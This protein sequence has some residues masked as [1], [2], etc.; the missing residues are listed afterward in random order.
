MRRLPPTLIVLAAVVLGVLSP[1]RS[2]G[3]DEEEEVAPKKPV[4]RVVVEDD[5]P[6]GATGV[7]DLQRAAASARHPE[8][9]K[10]FAGAA[11][12]C[13]R[14]NLSNGKT[15][16]VLL[17]PYPWDNEVR[18]FKGLD[19]AVSDKLTRFGAAVLD[20]E[21]NPGEPQAV[22]TKDVRGIVHFERFA[23]QE[24]D[25]LV[26]STATDAAPLA[27]RL[28]AGERA[29]TAV[30]FYHDAAVETNRRRGP[31]WEPVK[32]AVA[33]KLLDVRLLLVKE[34]AGAKNWSRLGE[35]ASKYADLYRNKPKVI[36]ELATARLAEAADLVKSA[37]QADLE[38]ARDI[39]AEFDRL[40]PGS[41]NETAKLVRTALTDRAKQKLN[42]IG[43]GA[44]KDRALKL[45]ND[46]RQLNP[47]DPDVLK[48]QKELRAGADT[49]VVGVPRMP[50]LMSPATAREDSERM[51]VEL[52]FEGLLDP[53]PDELLGR[54]YRPLLAAHQ[55]LVSPLARDLSLR[56]PSWGREKAGA[57][58][59]ADLVATVQLLRAQRALPSAEAADWLADAAPVPDAPDR[60]RVRFAAAHPD[61]RTLLTFKVLPG[62]HL[63][64]L[65]KGIDDQIGRDSFARSPFGTGPFQLSPE[66]VPSDDDKPVRQIAFVPNRGRF[67]R[68]G[69]PELAEIR[70]VPTTG[71]SPADLA[72]DLAAGQ[73]H[74]LTDVPTAD[75]EKYQ[76]VEGTKVVTAAANRRVYILAVNHTAELLKTPD[77]RRGISLA[78]DREAI[79][80]ELYRAGTKHHHALAGPFPVGSWLAPSTPKPLHDRDLAAGKLRDVRGQVKLL[81]PNDD[82]RA[83]AA[84]KRIADAV[85]AAGELK[86]EPEGVTPVELRTRVEQQGRYEL[87]Y[88][89]FDYPDIWHAHTLAALLDPSAAGGGG[90]NFLRFMAKG[91]AP[92]RA[93]ERLAEAL[94]ELKTHRDSEGEIKKAGR[95]V[96]DHFLEAT[97]FVPLWQLD[98][99]MVVSTSLKVYFD[100]GGEAGPYERLDPI[101]LFSNVGRWKL[102]E[103]K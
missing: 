42:D 25:R 46:A 6:G 32:A 60:V 69:G 35:L 14:I 99:H 80:N 67:G 56:H 90:R 79:L 36:Q 98:R 12:A 73:L 22:L 58:D 8:L 97:P 51:A 55:P 74:L 39:L 19:K 49:L 66:F 62:K 76:S 84:C 34:V 65:R 45:L 16:R 31:A 37:R 87:A 28:A 78:I 17:L 63:A 93:D 29:L 68:V 50:R 53:R 101:T 70:L 54:V 77:V 94:A 18:R 15:V 24:T 88:L 72:R 86:V 82:P 64:G 30:L 27:D 100:D 92:S 52:M 71:R 95:E 57:F 21:N 13:D 40:V 5:A 43:S 7:P 47:D 85:G 1:P 41:D 10:F 26:S 23:I 48:K 75:L 38:R 2:A 83:E 9:K 59:A 44:D 4:K 3:R 11:V 96:W 33:D 89:P 103:P 102:E 61:P 91:A 81:Y 20:E